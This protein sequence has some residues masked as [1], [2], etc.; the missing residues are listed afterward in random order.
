VR[1]VKAV[2]IGHNYP[3]DPNDFIYVLLFRHFK[4]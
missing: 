2:K 4:L 1:A 3:L